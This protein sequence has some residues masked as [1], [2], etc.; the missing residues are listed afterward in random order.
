[1]GLLLAG[2]D[3]ADFRY[4]YGPS[5]KPVFGNWMDAG[6]TSTEEDADEEYIPSDTDYSENEWDED[7]MSVD[8]ELKNLEDELQ[9]T[10]LGNVM[11]GMTNVFEAKEI[12]KVADPVPRTKKFGLCE[13]KPQMTWATVEDCREFFHTKAIKNKFSTQQVRNDRE[14]YILECKDPLSKAYKEPE[15]IRIMGIIKKTDPKDLDWYCSP[16]FSVEAF[17]ATYGNY[18]YPLDNIK[19]W[20]EI[21]G[22]NEL[23]LPPEQTKQAGRPRKQRIRGEDEP[24][25]T[26]R[27][28]KKCG[29]LGHNALT[30]E[31]RQ[32]RIYGKKGKS[33]DKGNLIDF[34]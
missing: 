19:D 14:R 7:A 28:C 22:P 8:E 23:V 34:N 29:T 21:E 26:K 12:A 17:R 1:M 15:L 20:P 32:K 33:K 3:T 5:F 27:K 9:G 10:G 16:Y 25:K 11:K 13:L 24:H 6:Y 4:E 30:C 18:I 2:S 31:V